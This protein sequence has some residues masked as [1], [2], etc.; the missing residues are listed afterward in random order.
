MLRP[1]VRF[2]ISR[3]TF[4]RTGSQ[5]SSSMKR[6]STQV[7]QVDY[8]DDSKYPLLPGPVPETFRPPTLP[9]YGNNIRTFLFML[10]TSNAS[11]ANSAEAVHVMNPDT[12]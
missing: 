1:A 10:Q 5:I 7:I 4:P 2:M 3:R 9:Q 6:A 11:G 12:P 8:G